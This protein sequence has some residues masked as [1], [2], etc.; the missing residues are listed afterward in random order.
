MLDAIHENLT[1]VVCPVGD[2]CVA[3]WR[4]VSG[5]GC[6]SSVCVA[7]TEHQIE[8]H[9]ERRIDSLDR[10]YLRGELSDADYK[11]QIDEIDAWATRE[12]SKARS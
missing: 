5:L 4:G 10:R 3:D 2:A 9:V 12:Y 1:S 7:M 11:R 6:D 8:M